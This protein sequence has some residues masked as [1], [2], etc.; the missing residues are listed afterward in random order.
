MAAEQVILDGHGSRAR[1]HRPIDRLYAPVEISFVYIETKSPWAVGRG[2][3]GRTLYA[4]EIED[5]QP[6]VRKPIYFVHKG[7]TVA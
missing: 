2:G 4:G 1:A 5:S 7:W 3:G 6:E